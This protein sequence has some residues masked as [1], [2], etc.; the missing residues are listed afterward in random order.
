M[1]SLCQSKFLMWPSTPW[2]PR[3]PLL[4]LLLRKSSHGSLS[5]DSGYLWCIW[6]FFEILPLPI[7][8]R[9]NLREMAWAYDK[10]SLAAHWI[11]SSSLRLFNRDRWKKT[12]SR[13][14]AV[15]TYEA[16]LLWAHFH[17]L[18]SFGSEKGET[19]IHKEIFHIAY[20][21]VELQQC[22]LCYGLFKWVCHQ[23]WYNQMLESLID[24]GR[25]TANSD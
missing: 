7:T 18:A 1:L 8:P 12:Y 11:T 20:F 14:S 23:E 21:L 17:P 5:G 16:L 9:G 3:C 6:A 19:I 25:V 24:S 13:Y 22:Q 10:L 2:L 15:C 4:R